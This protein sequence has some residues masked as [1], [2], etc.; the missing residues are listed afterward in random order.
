MIF[1]ETDDRNISSGF[2]SLAFQETLFYLFTLSF[3]LLEAEPVI[4]LSLLLVSCNS[5]SLKKEA[6]NIKLNN[7]KLLARRASGCCVEAHSQK[8]FKADF[9]RSSRLP[10]GLLSFICW[11]KAREKSRAA[12]TSASF[13]R[14]DENC[15]VVSVHAGKKKNSSR[16]STGDTICSRKN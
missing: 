9:Y 16:P 8:K 14:T 11:L 6:R 10:P 3:H 4:S 12:T 15:G 13:A 2:L 7:C 1:L 5:L